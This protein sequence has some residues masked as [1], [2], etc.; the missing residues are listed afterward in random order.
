LYNE[1][2]CAYVDFGRYQST[3]CAS[4]NVTITTVNHK[5]MISLNYFSFG[6]LGSG[7]TRD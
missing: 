2:L 5:P 1:A 6:L 4:P 3:P 7:P